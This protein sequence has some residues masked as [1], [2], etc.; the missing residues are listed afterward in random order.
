[1]KG[2]KKNEIYLKQ[3]L[4]DRVENVRQ[5]MLEKQKIKQIKND[6]QTKAHQLN[7]RNNL[8]L[9]DFLASRVP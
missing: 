7:G 9:F 2:S 5:C 8:P 4:P 6:K 3:Y 1:M